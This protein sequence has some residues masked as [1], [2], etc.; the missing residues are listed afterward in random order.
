MAVLSY[1]AYIHSHTNSL[2]LQAQSNSVDSPRSSC[3]AVI[4]V[5]VGLGGLPYVILLEA[6]VIACDALCWCYGMLC[7]NVM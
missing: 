5:F 6:S 3:K 4:S 7:V 2:T 1:P